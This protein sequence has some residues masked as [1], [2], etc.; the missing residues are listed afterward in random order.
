M[1]CVLSIVSPSSISVMTFLQQHSAVKKTVR[2]QQHLA[3]PQ[4]SKT[5]WGLDWPWRNVWEEKQHIPRLSCKC[6][7]FSLSNMSN[8]WK[9]GSSSG[10][11][12][13]FLHQ[14]WLHR[15]K[16]MGSVGVKWPITKIDGCVFFKQGEHI[17][18]SNLCVTYHKSRRWKHALFF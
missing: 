18:L 14:H 11:E 12:K 3:L 16:Q 4:M 10:I 7:F 9:N 1:A 13:P 6:C 17:C 15:F 2:G 5:W 8:Q